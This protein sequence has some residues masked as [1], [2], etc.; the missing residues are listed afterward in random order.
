MPEI[1]S[2]DKFSKEKSKTYL[3]GSSSKVECI[4]EESVVQISISS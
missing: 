4:K 1:S 2:N 3:T